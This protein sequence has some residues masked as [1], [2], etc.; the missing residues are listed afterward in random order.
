MYN[1]DR[2]YLY[3]V[4]YLS[5]IHILFKKFDKE[6]RELLE[7]KHRE[8]TIPDY[9][10]SRQR[11]MDDVITQFA[12]SYTHL[13]SR[14]FRKYLKDINCERLTWNDLS[15]QRIDSV[16]Y[17]HLDVYKRQILFFMTW[18]K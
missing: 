16:S 8:T 5:L 18:L 10:K 9:R 11:T 7:K 14:N 6:R 17:T 15:Q 12:V 3:H 1:I 13:I 2:A 4:K